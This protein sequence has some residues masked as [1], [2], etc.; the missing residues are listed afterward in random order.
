LRLRI[1]SK[2][3]NWKG[4]RF[5]M[6]YLV[7]FENNKGAFQALWEA[8]QLASRPKGIAEMRTALKID[9]QLRSIS[10]DALKETS[11]ECPK[12]SNRVKFT[13][14]IDHNMWRVDQPRVL[15]ENPEPLFLEDASFGYLKEMLTGVNPPQPKVR[16]FVALW[17][18]LE[19]TEKNWK[20]NEPE[21]R[22][23]LIEPVPETA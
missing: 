1:K 19:D 20:G 14:F 13:E 2:S 3:E 7:R 17:D 9:D 6:G 4:K 10:V 22:K 21:L 16:D 11:I 12:C 8:F 5:R 18:L 23:R 15:N